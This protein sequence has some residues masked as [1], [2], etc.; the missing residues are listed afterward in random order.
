[1]SARPVRPVG[2]GARPGE[3]FEQQ[4]DAP[5][6]SHWRHGGVRYPGIQAETSLGGGPRL[7]L[8]DAV[9]LRWVIRKGGAVTG[10]G[11]PETLKSPGKTLV[12]G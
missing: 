5:L 9:S 7:D 4:P 8:G 10:R 3:G 11:L 2:F 1:M 6:G 12:Q